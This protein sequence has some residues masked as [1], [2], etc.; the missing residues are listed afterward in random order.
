MRYI[1]ASLSVPL[2]WVW[3]TLTAIASVFLCTLPMTQVLGFEFAFIIGIPISLGAGHLAAALPFRWRK[4]LLIKGESFAET[5]PVSFSGLLAG[6]LLPP[7]AML[8][9]SLLI[10][11]TNRIFIPPC[12]DAQG[13]LFYLMLPTVSSLAAAIT[14]LFIGTLIP[15]KKIGIIGI[16]VW[17]MLWTFSIFLSVIELW[18]TPAVFSFGPFIGYWPGVWYDKYI[19]VTPAFL[20]YRLYNAVVAGWLVMV[21]RCFFYSKEIRLRFRVPSLK[22]A[23]WLTGGLCVIGV[24]LLSSDQLGHR[25]SANR[26]KAALV[27]H[28]HSDN[29]DIYFDARIPD[30]K[31]RELA[32]DAQFSLAMIKRFFQIKS[33]PSLTVYVFWDAAQKHAY[34]GARHTS[35]A[36]PWLNETYIVQESAPHWTL[37][38]ELAHLVAAGFGR[39]PFQI[40]TDHTGLVP[41][42]ALVE[43]IAVAAT[44]VQGPLSLHQSAKAMRE[45]NILPDIPQLMGI[46]FLSMYSRSAY[47]TA[48]SFCLYIHDTFGA[49]ALRQLYAGATAKSATG[50]S[51]ATI[52]FKW[53]QFLDTVT[54]SQE[55]LQM[56][57]YQFDRPSI[58]QSRCAREVARLQKNAA[59]QQEASQWQKAAD[60]LLDAHRVSGYATD[61]ALDLFFTRTVCD[62]KAARDQSRQLLRQ[63]PGIQREL[64]INEALIDMQIG[65][66]PL[67]EL[68][69]KY[70]AILNQTSNVDDKRR[71][72]A[73]FFFARM[74]TQNAETAVRYLNT[75]TSSRR[76]TSTQTIYA[77]N[78]IRRS[79]P[80]EPLPAYLSARILFSES[81]HFDAAVEMKRAL[82][83][84][85]AQIAPMFYA[86]ARFTLGRSYLHLGQNNR[87]AQQFGLIKIEHFNEAG[88]V[89]LAE[90]FYQRA[91]WQNRQNSTL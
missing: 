23:G 62:P 42:P 33:H 38:H 10:V 63:K 31:R 59:A 72:Y 20:S 86:Q 65:T 27:H 87:A 29:L 80:Y 49:T 36:K 89:A 5:A 1:A 76:P 25:T 77:L 9:L 4:S 16:A 39:G 50:H 81:A 53:H 79:L 67:A 12:N 51:M 43:G 73:K 19:S 60:S 18:R 34:M 35:V 32:T 55:D 41:I 24:F 22:A 28:I 90:D 57:R 17:Y 44:P 78:N 91:L 21:M 64:Q 58:V 54:V 37:R 2:F 30:M 69:V 48:G 82:S 66:V 3:L 88:Y 46:G 47:T 84:N 6:A 13:I 52:E 7:V 8:L 14:G 75:V 71:I 85:I 74:A 70:Q 15:Q 40:A 11:I 68:A 26:L 45:L 83:Q 61:T 56:V